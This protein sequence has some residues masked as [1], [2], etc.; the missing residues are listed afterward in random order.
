MTRSKLRPDLSLLITVLVLA[1]GGLVVL[2]SASVVLSQQRLGSPYGFL[3]H[4]LVFGVLIGLILG[5]AA[6]KFPY[7]KL[8]KLS[9][10]F[11]VVVFVGLAAVLVPHAQHGAG[12]AV[13]WLDFGWSTFQPSE[14][15]KLFLLIY[16]AALLSKKTSPKHQL[17]VVVIILILVSVLL[18]L[19]PDLSTLGVIVASCVVLYFLSGVKVPYVLGILI[20]G[21]LS[22]SLIIRLSPYRWQRFLTYLNPDVDVIGKSYQINQALLALGSGGLWGVGLGHSRQKFNYLPEPMGDSIFAILG[23]ELG[24]IGVIIFLFLFLFLFIRV[25]KIAK[26]ADTDFGRL[27]ALGIGFWLFL[28][29]FIN[30]AATCGLLPIAGVPLPFVSYGGSSMVVS[31]AAV[32]ILLN[33]SKYQRK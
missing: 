25:F 11:L 3:K 6:Y 20:S 33:I 1:I 23:E 29:A 31:L 26:N 17:V 19:Q 15:A 32:G 22:L 12:G 21:A 14:L 24:F 8:Q 28:Q 30:I 5:F 9:L 7:Q 10:L 2:S 27:L 4:Q 18:I 13:R 16:F